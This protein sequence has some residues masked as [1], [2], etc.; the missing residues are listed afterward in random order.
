MLRKFFTALGMA[1][2]LTIF[3]VNSVNAAEQTMSATGEY[4]AGAVESLNDAKQHALEDAM[5][6][7]AERAGVLVT[8]Y[9]KTH[10][11][12]LT[13]DEVTTVAAKI[14]RVTQKDFDVKLLSDSE[15]RVVVNIV[16]IVDT[17][18]I[19]ADIERIRQ[20]NKQLKEDV[21]TLAEDRTK[22]VEENFLRDKMEIVLS[23]MEETIAERYADNRYRYYSLDAKPGSYLWYRNQFI[24]HMHNHNY[25]VPKSSHKHTGHGDTCDAY[26]AIYNARLVYNNRVGAGEIFKENWAD[27][28]MLAMM[29]MTGECLFVGT[30]VSP[31]ERR[32]MAYDEF[33]HVQRLAKENPS[34]EI[35]EPLKYDYDKYMKIL[36]PWFAFYGKMAVEKIQQTQRSIPT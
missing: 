3:A 23:N 30:T 7:V 35:Y 21:S 29:I 9:S 26:E 8:S 15:I 14:I 12:T 33:L 10:N 6:Q 31:M 1:L 5:R 19:S 28:E 13:E 20:E 11:L 4:V 24:D 22:L 16:A 36:E 34:V 18:N 25:T 27:S 17:D 2:L 32:A